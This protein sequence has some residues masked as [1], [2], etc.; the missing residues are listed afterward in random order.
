MS[1]VEAWDIMPGLA[2]NPQL[3]RCP[4]YGPW[5][6]ANPCDSFAVVKSGSYLL[7]DTFMQGDRVT[8]LVQVQEKRQVTRH[9]CVL[10]MK[11][12]LTSSP[13]KQ[14]MINRRCIHISVQGVADDGSPHDATLPSRVRDECLHII[15]FRVIGSRQQMGCSKLCVALMRRFGIRFEEEACDDWDAQARASDYIAGGGDHS[16]RLNVRTTLD[17]LRYVDAI[18]SDG[19]LDDPPPP[20]P[21]SVTPSPVAPVP[22]PTPAVPPRATSAAEPPAAPA[23]V[24]PLSPLVPSPGELDLFLKFQQF[25]LMQAQAIQSP[26]PPSTPGPTTEAPPVRVDAQAMHTSPLDVMGEDERIA[27]QGHKTVAAKRRAASRK[28]GNPGRR[29]LGSKKKSHFDDDIES[30]N[31]SLPGDD[32][33][34]EDDDDEAHVSAAPK[35][36]VPLGQVMINGAPAMDLTRHAELPRFRYPFCRVF[37]RPNMEVI[38]QYAFSWFHSCN[39]KLDIYRKFVDFHNTFPGAYA[40]EFLASVARDEGHSVVT[41]GDLFIKI[42]R[43]FGRDYRTLH[44]PRD[45]QEGTLLLTLIDNLIEGKTEEGV[46]GSLWMDRS[47]DTLVQRFK[48]IRRLSR[49]KDGGRKAAWAA[50]QIKEVTNPDPLASDANY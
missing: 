29:Q 21:G 14:L 17:G 8:A 34:A 38:P 32:D 35:T 24:H 43:Y 49:E 22:S 27:S 18:S 28:Q 15:K 37:E 1:Q 12:F 30:S 46:P 50:M 6:A 3:R 5:T 45:A 23:V 10:F 2:D 26:I 33:Y 16:P 42:K 11:P 47:L 36:E 9:G 48:T 20:P 40:F 41:V 4:V 13:H 44:D 25:Q 19:S 7:I 31:A 39:A